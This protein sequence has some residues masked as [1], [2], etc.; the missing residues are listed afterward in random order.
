MY[1]VWRIL[2][3]TRY[4]TASA[5]CMFLDAPIDGRHVVAVQAGQAGC[6]ATIEAMNPWLALPLEDY[7][8]HMRFGGGGSAGAAR[9]PLRGSAGAAASALGGGAGCGRRQRARARGQHADDARRRHRRQCRV[10]RRHEGP[11][12]RPARPRAPLR[13]PRARHAEPGAGVAGARR[14]VLRACGHRAVSRHRGLTGGARRAPLG[15]SCSCRR[16]S[17]RPSR[18]R[19]TRRWPRSPATSPSSIPINCGG[20]LAQRDLRLTHQARR[21]LS[22][23]KAF[24]SGYFE[25]A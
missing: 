8:G 4:K 11:V 1:G 15:R 20:V 13:R 19:R 24:W 3:D 12:P 22:T 23:G 6:A 10:S 14:A 16:R 7:E 2:Y 18:R 17:T 21:T 25:R 5:P 9:R